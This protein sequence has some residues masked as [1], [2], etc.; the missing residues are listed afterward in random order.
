MVFQFTTSTALTAFPSTVIEINFLSTSGTAIKSG[1]T[2]RNIPCGIV[3]I[4]K[5]TSSS[6]LKCTLVYNTIPKIRI[7]NHLA[8]SASTTVTIMLYDLDNSVIVQSFMQ[9]SD[10]EVVAYTS[11]FS[12]KHIARLHSMYT[13]APGSA[14]PSTPTLAFPSFGSP[15]YYYDT[16]NPVLNFPTTTMV[17][18]PTGKLLLSIN[19]DYNFQGT[20][21]TFRIDSTTLTSFVDTVNSKIVVLS[22]TV[23]AGTHTF[24]LT[25]T[26]LYTPKINGNAAG[27]FTIQYSTAS[28]AT[29]SIYTYSTSP[30]SLELATFSGTV[31]GTCTPYATGLS[32]GTGGNM[33]CVMTIPITST[34]FTISAIKLNFPNGGT[35]YTKILNYCNAFISFGSSTVS[36]GQLLCSRIDTSSTNAGFFITGWNFVTGSEITVNM[37]IT[38]ASVA[39][40]SVA[41][42]LQTLISGSY[43]DL[44]TTSATLNYNT[45]FSTTLSATKSFTFYD[46]IPTKVGVSSTTPLR[47]A[48]DINSALS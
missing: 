31:T 26:S 12:G 14:S 29:S 36:K 41:V 9:Y 38:S 6:N 18:G 35:A 43:Y 30:P 40:A 20:S 15:P 32:V 13:T 17:A 25:G 23:S 27:D 3:G 28:F 21:V 19:N 1:L 11:S 22:A 44:S 5:R 7:E 47:F 34:S 39:S 42:T 45:A 16:S 48:L 4:S 24:Q 37:K 10:F 33:N 46:S 8:I 2:S